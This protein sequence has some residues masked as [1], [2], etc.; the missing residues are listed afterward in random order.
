MKRVTID[1]R[2]SVTAQISIATQALLGD[3]IHARR[4][5]LIAA[6]VMERSQR[7]GH[8]EDIHGRQVSIHVGD[9]VVGALGQRHALH[10]H[11]GVIPEQLAVGDTIHMLNLGGVMGICQTSN[12]MVGP[13]TV[14]EVLGSVLTFP[15]I[16]SREGVPANLNMSPWASTPELGAEQVHEVPPLIIISGTCMNA[17]K[18]QAASVVVRA[19]KR[20]GLEV[21]ATKLTGVAARKDVLSMLDCGASKAMTFVD[22]GLPSTSPTSAPGAARQLLHA[23]SHQSPSPDVIVVEMGDG[24]LG[25]YGVMEILEDEIFSQIPALHICCASDP[26]GSF[27]AMALFESKLGKRPDLFTGPVTDNHIGC[28]QIREQLDTQALNAIGH[29]AEFGAAVLEKFEKLRA[30]QKELV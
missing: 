28:Q 23:L 18:T 8:L 4:G 19:L 6:R 2:G 25:A 16:D 29:A 15:V 27:G 10:G 30:R 17:G 1:K 14:L 22:V 7:Y 5:E 11:G 26:V 9:V 13:P 20:A 21:S 3:T 24:L 12:P